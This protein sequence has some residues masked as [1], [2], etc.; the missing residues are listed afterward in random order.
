M[1]NTR[2]DE[3]CA[4]NLLKPFPRYCILPTICVLTLLRPNSGRKV[5][6]SFGAPRSSYNFRETMGQTT[7]W[8]PRVLFPS[9]LRGT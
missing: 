6:G 5:Y 7:R 8:I 4:L 3:I 9:I 2:P 1:I